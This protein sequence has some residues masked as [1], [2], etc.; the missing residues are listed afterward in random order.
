MRNRRNVSNLIVET[1]VFVKSIFQTCE[2]SFVFNLIL[3]LSN[4]SSTCIL[5]L[6]T[7]LLLTILTFLRDTI[8]SHVS[9]IIRIVSFVL[10]VSNQCASHIES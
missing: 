2:N 5:I 1:N 8:T 7:H 6:N 9:L 3:N 4:V 10:T